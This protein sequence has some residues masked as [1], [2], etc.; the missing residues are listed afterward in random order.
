MGTAAI[1]VAAGPGTRLGKG[2]PKAFV[3]LADA[4]LFVHTMRALLR[5]SRID[6]VALIVPRGW[7]TEAQHLLDTTGPW[8][9]RIDIVAGGQE[10]QDSVGA[11]LERIADAEWVVVHDA[12]RPFVTTQVLDQVIAAAA[13]EG[14]AIAAIPATDTIKRVE[15]DRR[16]ASTLPRERLWLAQTPQVFR[17]ELLRRAH[18]QSATLPAPATDDAALVEAIGVTVCVVPGTAENRK[19]TTPDDL[20]WAEW[21]LTRA[22]PR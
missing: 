18:A 10:R 8:R 20:E 19:I 5:C 15:S 21:L 14:A 2:V 17:T 9:C 12:A 16:I 11:G 22:G 4:P 1:L 7:E 6:R 3:R 13:D